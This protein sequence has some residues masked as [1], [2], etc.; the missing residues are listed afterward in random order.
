MWKHVCRSTHLVDGLMMYPDQ[1]RHEGITYRPL[2]GV[3]GVGSTGHGGHDQSSKAAN[4][5]SSWISFDI[6]Q[7][8]LADFFDIFCHFQKLPPNIGM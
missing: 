1:V 3:P 7:A 2:V 6:S 4:F 5:S 8:L